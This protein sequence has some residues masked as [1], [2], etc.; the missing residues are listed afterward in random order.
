[1]N[2]YFLSSILNINHTFYSFLFAQVVLSMNFLLL[3]M[4]VRCTNGCLVS[5]SFELY[6]T[7][8]YC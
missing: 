2:S 1:M 5:F 3:P 7:S 8:Y 4:T 6:V